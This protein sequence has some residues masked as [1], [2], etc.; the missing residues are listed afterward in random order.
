MEIRFSQTLADVPFQ[1]NNKANSNKI[2]LDCIYDYFEI[3]CIIGPTK[4]MIFFTIRR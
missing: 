3:T 2:S 1:I 4:P